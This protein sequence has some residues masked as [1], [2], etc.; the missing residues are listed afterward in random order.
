M[1]LPRRRFLHLAAGAVA[2]PAVS[3]VANAQSYP[4]RPVRAQ[5]IECSIGERSISRRPNQEPHSIRSA[6][7]AV[8]GQQFGDLAKVLARRVYPSPESDALH[9]AGAV[10]L[11]WPAVLFCL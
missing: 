7:L 4:T 11:R 3:R 5:L 10:A 2:M 8:K 6:G 1:K 9:G